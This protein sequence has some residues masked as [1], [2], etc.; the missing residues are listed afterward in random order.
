MKRSVTAGLALMLAVGTVPAFCFADERP[1]N[2]QEHRRFDNQEGAFLRDR[3]QDDVLMWRLGEYAANHAASV[4]VRE[5]GRDISHN[6]QDDLREIQRFSENHRVNV[7]QPK[8]LNANQQRIYDDLTRKSGP[9]FDRGYTK[10]L[11]ERYSD[12][13]KQYQIMSDH[14]ADP[15]VRDYA[16]HRL[17]QLKDHQRQAHDAEREVWGG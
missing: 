7:E 11:A 5:L 13:V 2:R 16:S 9:D 10:V 1:E 4:R 8:H 6:R 12:S 14:A 15:E 3:A 17:G